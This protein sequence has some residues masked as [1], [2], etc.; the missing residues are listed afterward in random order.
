METRRPRSS[1]ATRQALVDAAR[2][3]FTVHG[4]PA[5]S[6]EAIA[7]AAQ[8]TKGAL[9]HHF[10]GKQAV[11]EAALELVQARA[12]ATIVHASAQHAD[13]WEQ[14]QAG[15][16]AFLRVAQEPDYRQIVVSDGPSVLG[17]ARHRE[18]ERS[19]YAVVAE[20]VRSALT[21]LDRSPDDALLDTSAR[22]VFGAVSAA[23]GSVATSEDPA[24]AAVRA[25]AAIGAIVTG[26]RR[27]LEDT[28]GGDGA[29]DPGATWR[30]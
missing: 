24:A 9:Y 26:L 17:P 21:G 20:L 11:F 19:T 8:L 3:L 6:L 22:V 5:A 10:S 25:E 2:E 15:L 30:R 7:E 23:G 18:H 12:S 27:L 28:A 1:D 16:R 29:T 4:Y 14:G 13:P